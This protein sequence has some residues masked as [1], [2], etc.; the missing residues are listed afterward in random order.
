MD[1]YN[2]RLIVEKLVSFGKSWD[3][4]AYAKTLLP[5][6]ETD[7]KGH[8]PTNPFKNPLKFLFGVI[9]DQGIPFEKAWA[10]PSELERRLGH[11]DV[12]IIAKMNEKDLAAIL[13]KRAALH[14]FNNKMAAWIIAASKLLLSKYQG[15]AEN[16]WGGKPGAQVLESRF[17]GFEGISQ[18]K[19]SMALNILVRDY[20]LPISGSKEAIDISY[21]VHVRRVFLRTGLATRDSESEILAAA[22][23]LSPQYPGELDYPSWVVGH[24]WCH[25]K[26]PDCSKCPIDELCPKNHRDAELL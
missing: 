25:R 1:P 4:P 13:S 26:N 17:R 3:E 15:N 11:L 12:R 21:D 16:I 23:E 8:D 10:A 14:R 7:A 2:K 9:F 20:D 22:R 5:L 6:S 19:G 24:H 18:K